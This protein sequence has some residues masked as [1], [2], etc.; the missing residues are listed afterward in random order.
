MVGGKL[1]RVVRRFACQVNSPNRTVPT[2]TATV[3]TPTPDDLGLAGDV[4]A[5]TAKV[6]S[7][8][9]A[10]EAAAFDVGRKTFN[11]GTKTFEVFDQIFNGKILISSHLRE[12]R[13]KPG[14]ICRPHL[15]TPIISLLTPM[16]TENSTPST[17]P[18]ATP[19]PAPV[20]TGNHPHG[21]VNQEHL[22]EIANSRAVAKAALDPAFAAALA[23]VEFDT[24]LPGQITTLADKIEQDIGKL[25]GTKS[26][27]LA[28]TAE[29]LAARDTLVAVLAPIQ[30]AA[31]RKFTGTQTAWRQAYFIGGHLA[32]GSLSFAATA[33]K[34]IRDRLV[35]VP[36]ATAPLDVLKGIGPAQITGLINTI[37]RFA[38][39]ISAADT[40]QNLNLAAHNAIVANLAALAALRHQVQLAA[41]QAYPWRASGVAATRQA[42]LL[43]PN[44][45]LPG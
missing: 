13:R 34:A 33:A 36:P 12:K 22:D 26:G 30:T 4:A 28:M 41:E 27:S 16:N 15:L 42:F 21:R 14:K 37:T 31:R 24:T 1:S 23:G 38:G 3:A 39:D 20:A 6:G 18:T 35:A 40:Q 9:S 32:H 17:T 5:K 11:V 45:P 44:R 2:A 25:T 10:V 19:T 29:Q 7:P 43:P 8:T